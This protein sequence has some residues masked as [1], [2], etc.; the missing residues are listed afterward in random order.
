MMKLLTEKL[1]K[2]IPKL[3]ETETVEGPEK[4]AQVKLFLPG[5][6]WTWYLIEYDGEDHCF[7]LVDSGMDYGGVEFGYFSI[8]EI[9]GLKSP[10]G[11][12]VERDLH[13][14]PTKIDY[15]RA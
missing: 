14:E 10:W 1:R 15:I 2:S 12:K 5:T 9:E 6:P 3:Y 8:K 13:W 7:G 4:V 11:L